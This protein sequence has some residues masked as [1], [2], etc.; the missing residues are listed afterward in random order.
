MKLS[1]CMTSETGVIQVLSDICFAHGARS[2]AETTLRGIEGSLSRFRERHKRW[3]W[4][5]RDRLLDLSGLSIFRTVSPCSFV[6]SRR[7]PDGTQYDLMHT[8]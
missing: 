7:Q 3:S 8:F 4:S 5:D 1:C 6:T 2:A